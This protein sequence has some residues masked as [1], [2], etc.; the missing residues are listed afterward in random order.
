MSPELR[1]QIAD[2]VEGKIPPPPGTELL[3]AM[4]QQARQRPP[5]YPKL[6]G[7]LQALLG[8]NDDESD[9]R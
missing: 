1:Q 2:A 7:R 5:R 6:Q 3:V 9:E 8:N 4:E